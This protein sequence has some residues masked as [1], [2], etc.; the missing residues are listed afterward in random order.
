M[1]PSSKVHC[2]DGIK[3]YHSFTQQ[4]FTHTKSQAV[5]S[6]EDSSEQNTVLAS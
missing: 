3:E 1:I 2:E 6:D 5:L 4:V